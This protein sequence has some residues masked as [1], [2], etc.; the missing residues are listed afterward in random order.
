MNTIDTN[1]PKKIIGIQFS[2]LSPE[3]IR[4][5][6]VVEITSRDTYINNKPVINGVFDPRLG[7]IDPGIICPTDG[8]NF[9]NTPGY[10]GHIEL[11][12]P[13][14]YIQYLINILK[15]LKC[16]CIKCSKLLIDKEKY[17]YLLNY[18]NDKRWAMAYQL[19]NKI[20]RC[21]EDT[22]CGCG[23][24]QPSKIKKEGLATIMAEW[25]KID[26]VED[27]D[28]SKLN[29]RLLPEI[30]LKI[31]KRISDEDV[32]F[33]GFSPIW[34][35]PEWMICQAMAI[36]PPAIRPSIKHDSQQRSE[37]DLTHIITNIIKANNTLR[38]KVIQNSN[39]TI[40][41]DWSTVLQYYVATLIDNKIPGVASVA[42]R[43]GRP[44]KSLKERLNGKSGRVRGNLMG[45]RVDFSARSVI[46]PD[47]NLSIRELGIPLKIAKNLTKPVVV[48][49]L[50]KRF[51]MK[52][53]NNGPDVYPG[54]KIYEKKNGESISLRYVDK[55]SIVLEN[56]DKVHRH[57]MNGDAVLFNRQPTLHKM[58]M[59]CHI[60]HVMPVGDTFRMNVGVT[61]P[62]NADFDGDEMNLHMPQDEEAECEL[63][64]LAAT[65]HQII[66]PTNNKSI[67]GIFQDSLLGSYQ[68]TRKGIQFD[69]RIAMNLLMHYKN[70]DFTTINFHNPKITNFEILSQIL[71]AISLKYKTKRFKDEENISDSN[72]VLE[73]KNGKYIRGQIEKGIFGD[74]SRGLIQ[75]IFND[76]N[77]ME[78][79]NFI[80]NIQNIVTEY[81][82]MSGYSVGISDL[83]ANTETNNRISEAI[84][85]KKIEVR[86]LIDETHLGIFENKSGKT[87]VDEFEQRVNNIL[88]KAS[89]EA[90]KIGRENLDQDNRFVIMVNAG[91][92]GSDLNISQMISCLGQQNVDGKRIP[93]GFDNR[94]LPHF[95]KY[96]DS[97]GA[98]GFVESCFIGGLKPEELFFHAM[99]GRVGLIDTAVKSV[100][101]DT[102]IIFI[103]N[104]DLIYSEIGKWIDLKLDAEENKTL[105]ENHSD[106]NLELMNTQNIYIPTTNEDGV[107]SWGEVTAI[108]RHDPGEKLYQI[109]TSGGKEVIVTENKSLLIW[110][111]E[112][113][114]LCET[115]SA[116]IKIGDY[117]PATQKLCD[118]P[119]ETIKYYISMEKY[120]PKDKYI[121]GNDFNKAKLSMEK[122]MLGRNQIPRNWWDL[123]NNKEFILPYTKKASLQRCIVRSN[124]DNIKDGYI[125]PYD[126]QRSDTCIP[127]KFM[128]NNKNGIFIGLYLSEG[129]V[130]DSCISITNNN[131]NIIDFVKA[132]FEGFNIHYKVYCTK[133]KIGTSTTI[134]GNSIIMSTFLKNI[135]GVGSANKFVPNDA[136]ISSTDFIKGLLNGYFSGDGYISKNSVEASSASKRLIEGINMLCSR[137]GIFGKV[138]TT[139]LKSNNL[140]TQ[141]ILP[142]NR[143][144]IRAQWGKLFAQN[145]DLIEE[146]KN[147]K[148][149]NIVWSDNHRNFKSYNDIVLDKIIEINILGVEKYPK[150]YDLTVPSTLN[151]GL[152]NGLQVRD[153]S[154]TGYIQ[155][156]LVKGLEDLMVTYDLS[157]R[158]NKNKIIQF[159]YGDDCFDPVKV[160]T[161]QI[162]FVFMT[163]EEVYAHF[164]MP[165]DAKKNN[166]YS[167]LYSKPTYSR[168]RRQKAETALK[169]KSYI[170]NMLSVRDK[171]VEN[172]L[173][174]V[175]IKN[176][177]VPVA[178]THLINN[179]KGTQEYNVV[180]DI[181]P[182]EVFG[183]IEETY[184]QLNTMY[185]I[186][187]NALFKALYYYYLSPKEL[188]MTHKLC[189]NSIELLMVYIVRAYKQAIINPGEMVG[190]IAAQSIGEPTTQ[191]TLNSV[192]YDTDIIVRNRAG[193]I[194]KIQM[195]EFI[196]QKILI[197]LKTE[198]YEDKDTMYAEIN[199][200]EFYEI[201][202]ATEDGEITWNT[203]EAV[204]R[205]PVVN[206]DGTNTLLKV[207]TEHGRDVTATKAKSFLQLREGKIVEVNGKDLKVGDYLPVS[208]KPIDFTEVLTLNLK[209]IFL[210]TEYL[211]TSEIDKAKSVLHEYHWWSKHNGKTFTVPYARGDTLV[212]K[213]NPKCRKGCKTTWEF[214]PGCVYPFPHTG[215][216]K[217]TI[218]EEIQLDY[219]FG[220][221]MGAYCAE[222]CI[223]KTQISIANIEPGYFDPIERLCRKYNITT[224]IYRHKNKG[225]EGWTSQDIRIYSVMMTRI[226]EKF[227]GKLSHGK[228]VHD[229]I[230]FS[231][232]DC[233]KGFLDA[234]IAGDGC[235]CKQK[236]TISIGSVSKD[237]IWDVHQIL[238]ILGIYSL[239]RIPKKRDTPVVFPTYTTPVENIKQGYILNI[240][241]MQAHK[242][243][244]ILNMKIQRKQDLL[245]HILSHI[246]KYEYCRNDLI[247]PNIINDV[248]IMEE[249]NG[250]YKNIYFDKIKSIEEVPNPTKY[251]YDLT[252]ELTRNF[253]TYNGVANSDTFH[254]AGVA[255]KS[256]VTRG[257]PRIEEILS[258]SEN[259]KAPS[260]TVYFP[261][262]IEK[263]S[264][265]VKSYINKIEY[266]KL[267]D[268]VDSMEICFDPDELNTLNNED[269][270]LFEQYREFEQLL[271]ECGS[272]Q[273]SK[274]DKSKWIIRI[275]LNVENMLDKNITM[276]DIHFA[277]NNAYKH[278]VSCVYSDYNSDKLIF[279][280]RLNNIVQNKK[281]IVVNP[282]DQSDEI[283][284]LTNF[285][286]DLLDNLILY[287]VKKISK[288]L[289]RKVPNN[290]VEVEGVYQRQESW[291]LDTVGTNLMRILALD[292]VDKTRTITNDIIEIHRILGV[293]A[294]R[295]AIKNEFSEVIEFDGTYINDH[296]MSMLA[297]RMCCNDKMVSIFRHGIN[298]DDVGPIAKASFEETPEIFLKAARHAELD[299]MKG[300]SANVM[301]GQEGYFGTSSFQVMLDLENMSEL[302]AE[303]EYVHKDDIHQSNIDID[304]EFRDLED[305]SEF[306][307]AANLAISTNIENIQAIDMGDD[308]DY[309]VG[310]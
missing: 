235:I 55:D 34:S 22:N 176:V 54:A 33:M 16:V 85:A 21:G 222:G 148:L 146:E 175:E 286:D 288:V 145:I 37:D 218:P 24:K 133:N 297:D 78:S 50:N 80:D 40:I 115:Y 181:T 253:N 125:Y 258:L 4:K 232:Q 290:L 184:K 113:N 266:T 5:A 95:T 93:Y 96:D 303:S 11:A 20:K 26:G 65:T 240:E 256:N 70:I 185:Y 61:K 197:S 143:I 300:V 227:G 296:H 17:N 109:K 263:D 112:S 241:N 157:V 139:I 60:A 285:Q 260:C 248:L 84:T 196:E 225:K 46:T 183:I 206:E 172:V 194:K 160:E 66:S 81:M 99:G 293:E 103:E 282:L 272:E 161:Q 122:N 79:S 86:N 287:G 274:K 214:E 28:K 265:Q 233:L 223:T 261:K 198:Y 74:S 164:Q 284:L 69:N 83:I 182:L 106:R 234:Y 170:D 104:G 247:V 88:N 9:I 117:V 249:R 39:S 304:K 132:W 31:F 19:C 129:H 230:I 236:K 177:N 59:M 149:Q 8:H 137:L 173:K 123:N 186:K 209:E 2:I 57:I 35:R 108:T 120:F 97:P 134:T 309:D 154:V 116:D 252:V 151:F 128:L 190:I 243:A 254:F 168:Y 307:S 136:F 299:L 219:D 10:F 131:T 94:T 239:V 111:H 118:P 208:R 228:F 127:E 67:I 268:V 130:N 140:N 163:L 27:D 15:I 87:N 308:D 270:I 126:A 48:N 62:Y 32:N 72:N 7:T 105:I 13:V 3:E 77:H 178:F 192:T 221:L 73:I 12:K 188:L 135:C 180:I 292:F 63:L 255:S 231:N 262:H 162:P 199:D 277:I 244:S 301:C 92:K 295:Q 53:I 267:R 310:F 36:P 30:I 1:N 141:N 82:K 226:V 45:K 75:R 64:N 14:F 25:E 110:N 276:D 302:T 259:P 246:Y 237:L 215:I 71:P 98:R 147:E 203:I 273:L 58:S 216:A 250:R 169:C 41:D 23:C 138:F 251:V 278:E 142:A 152:A 68:F 144:S 294:A 51:L 275:T 201:P 165:D 155:R 38:E 102:P 179:I 281:K 205:H 210:P 193:I 56:D 207:T 101:W 159:T 200:D 189:K 44:L 242:L 224:K 306:C 42:Q 283:Y 124:I 204:T 298:N 305:T 174:K 291:V 76:Y 90:G 212:E 171:I 264:E 43:S 213:V 100:T 166:V 269:E 150:M 257:V 271:D 153:T 217:S 289:L 89:L 202:S 49:D 191:L 158:N 280:I 47:P 220:Y 119:I 238:N 156:R 114:K 121:Y 52:L 187:E 167:T 29:M 107:V 245:H 195:G 18:P 279:R 211:Y 91:S 229:R 6:S